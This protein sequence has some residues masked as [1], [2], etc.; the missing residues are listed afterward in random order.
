[1]E[2]FSFACYRKKSKIPVERFFLAYFIRT[3]K[4]SDKKRVANFR[5]GE[6]IRLLQLEN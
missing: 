3:W 4:A 6:K 1:M 2:V 5:S